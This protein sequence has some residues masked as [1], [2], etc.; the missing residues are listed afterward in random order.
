MTVVLHPR[1]MN[2]VKN[3]P[4]LDFDE[5]V[6]RVSG[7]FMSYIISKHLLTAAVIPRG[8]DPRVQGFRRYGQGTHFIG[9]YKQKIN[10]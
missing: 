4:Y 3:H 1:L 10:P 6:K 9:C 8:K 2:E 5:A 7:Y